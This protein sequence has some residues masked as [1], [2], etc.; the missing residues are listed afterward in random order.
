MPA[1]VVRHAGDVGDGIGERLGGQA[2]AV[3][4]GEIA[5]VGAVGVVRR[6]AELVELRAQDGPHQRL[7]VEF[8]PHEFLPERVE[9]RG[10]RRRIR[11]AE[12]IHRIHDAAAEERAPHAVRRG[13]GEER[14]LRIGHPVGERAARVGGVVA[15]HRGAVGR[16]RLHH[17]AGHRMLHR[18]SRSENRTSHFPRRSARRCRRLFASS[19]RR[20]QRTGRSRPAPIFRSDDDGTSRS[21]AAR[22]GRAG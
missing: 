6:G 4:A 17:L 5:R 16:L 14:I 19:V 8:L 21:R 2:A 10:V 20:T 1:I 18:F 12:I 13:P 3:R 22:R 9:Q 15:F 11:N 7:E